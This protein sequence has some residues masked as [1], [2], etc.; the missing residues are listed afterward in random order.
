[1]VD[2]GTFRRVE[3]GTAQKTIDQRDALAFDA[4]GEASF[5]RGHIASADHANDLFGVLSGA[6]REKPVLIYCYHGNSSQV[7]AKASVDF[8]FREVFSLDGG[9]E[10]WVVAQRERMFEP[11][12]GSL[13]P[14]SSEVA[15]AAA[16]KG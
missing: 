14:V 4:P 1:M 11:R 6:P 12:I 13:A 5:E 15:P 7:F 3:A 9:Y 2:D 8:Q 10:G 16:T